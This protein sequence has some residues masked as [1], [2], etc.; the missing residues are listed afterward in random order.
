MIIIPPEHKPKQTQKGIFSAA[1]MDNTEELVLS[2]IHLNNQ[3]FMVQVQGTE[4][5]RIF[6]ISNTTSIGCGEEGRAAVN[7]PTSPIWKGPQLLT[8]PLQCCLRAK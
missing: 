8:Q 4:I 2:E 5:N 3:P 6:H 1:A 7:Q